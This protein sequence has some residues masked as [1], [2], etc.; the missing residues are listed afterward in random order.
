MENKKV[1]IL[2]IKTYIVF[3][4]HVRKFKEVNLN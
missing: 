4:I 2:K 1:K 3:N